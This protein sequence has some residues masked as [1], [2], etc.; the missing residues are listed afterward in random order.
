MTITTSEISREK[1]SSNPKMFFFPLDNGDCKNRPRYF[2]FPSKNEP[3]NQSTGEKKE[4][5]KKRK[6]SINLTE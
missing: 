5:K 3:G 6:N 1:N 4:N 2:I